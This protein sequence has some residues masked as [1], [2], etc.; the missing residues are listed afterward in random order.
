MENVI[1]FKLF[2]RFS[3]LR[4]GITT[5]NYSIN[6]LL[7]DLGFQKEKSFM[8]KQVHQ[9]NIILVTEDIKQ[10]EDNLVGDALITGKMD[11]ALIVRTADCL[12]IFLYSPNDHIIG[13][14]HGGW[15]S[16]AKDI[17]GKVISQMKTNFNIDVKSLYAAIGPAIKK[18]CYEVG[19]DVVR[20]LNVV[21]KNHIDGVIQKI[22]SQKWNLDLKLVAEK[23]LEELGIGASNIEVSSLCTH[24][25]PKLFFSYRR[26]KQ[27]LGDIFSVIGMKK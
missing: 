23:R 5:K 1:Q 11:V 21:Y 24:C 2:N 27:K 16:L 7:W 18:E 12:P 19:E 26:D 15:R 13:L 17:I 8:L 3:S 4:H 9:D 22:S 25:C 20:A 10:E 14:I 6:S